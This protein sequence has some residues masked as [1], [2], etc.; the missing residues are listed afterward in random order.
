MGFKVSGT[1]RLDQRIAEMPE[2]VRLALSGAIAE[3][4]E[5]LN[6]Y[7]RRL[8][9]VSQGGG[10]LQRSI[11][12]GWA[13]PGEVGLEGLRQ[14]RGAQI[15]KKGQMQLAAKAYAGVTDTENAYYASFVEFGTRYQRPSPFFYPAYRLKKRDIKRVMAQ[16]SRKAIKAVAAGQSKAA[17]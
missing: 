4:M 12:W 6:D 10:K 1:A 17:P 7:Q 16:A 3:G 13:K 8:V 9:P 2:A 15:S 14:G 11:G 5:I